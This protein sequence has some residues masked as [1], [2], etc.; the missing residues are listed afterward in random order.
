MYSLVLGIYR[1]ERMQH[2]AWCF[3]EKL[4]YGLCTYLH[5]VLI[6]CIVCTLKSLHLEHNLTEG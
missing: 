6:L 4:E 2:T 3:V 1:E 5:E